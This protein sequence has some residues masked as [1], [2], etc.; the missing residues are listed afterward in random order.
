MTR[1]VLLRCD[2]TKDLYPVTKP[3]TIPHAF[4]TSQYTWHQRREHP[5]SEV[6]RRLFSS[7][8]ISCTKEKAPVLC[9]ACQLGKHVRL[10]FVSS[11]TRYKA[12]LVANGSTQLEGIDVHETFSPVV[13][14]VTIR[15]VLSLATSWHWLV[16]QLD[17]NN[18]FLH[19]DLS[20]TVY[21]HQHLGFWGSAHPDY[22]ADT[23]YLLLYIDDIV[24]DD[25]VLTAFSE[26][27]YDAEILERAHMVNCNPNRSPVDT[28]SKLG[29]DVQQVCLYMHDSRN[30]YFSALKRTLW[31]VRG[32][33]N[34]V[35]Q[36]FSSSTT[37]LVAY[38]NADWAGCPTTRRLTS[39]YC[40]FLCNNLL[41]WSSKRQPTL[42]HSSVEAKY[43][44]VANV[45]AETCWLENL[46]RE[47]HT[48]LSSATLVYCDN[49]NAIYLSVNLVQHQRTKL[50]E[51]DIHFV[52]DLVDDGQVRVL[53]VLSRYQCIEWV[54]CCCS[55][56]QG[57]C[58]N[59]KYKNEAYLCK[60]TCVKHLIRTDACVKLAMVPPALPLYPGIHG[61]V[62]V[63]K[64]PF[65]LN[66]SGSQLVV[67]VDGS[68]IELYGSKHVPTDER[69]IEALI[70]R[71]SNIVDPELDEEASKTRLD[72]YLFD[73][74]GPNLQLLMPLPELVSP[75]PELVIH[76]NTPGLTSGNDNE[77]MMAK[78]KKVKKQCIS[79]NLEAE[80]N[81]RKRMRDNL[82]IIR[83]LVPKISKMDTIS[84]VGDTIKYIQELQEN[85]KELEDELKAF[86]EKDCMDVGVEVE[87]H[88]IGAR[89]YLLKVLC[90]HKPD[91]FS[92]LIEA[93]QS[94]GLKVI[95]VS[96]TTCMGLVLNTLTVEAKEEV[97]AKSL[98][99]SLLRRGQRLRHLNQLDV[100][101]RS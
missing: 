61:E 78:Q 8:S 81:R 77:F 92:M 25:I 28:E 44:S 97:D 15:T 42:S 35:L 1:R 43:R 52:Q 74:I 85:A 70:A 82:L 83:S 60:D 53:H 12:R 36:L 11:N 2:S 99:D 16:H 33:F 50:I 3:S 80:R 5:G 90:S 49:V 54:G 24:L 23:A 65:W 84:I 14:P 34:H 29:D 39:G 37:S 27:K 45:V 96:M 20:E 94:L 86:E 72:S 46:L 89:K 40:V 51:I 6:L 31:Y 48:P 71:L 91:G 58:G 101:G 41:S 38:S 55:G 19:G 26:C 95:N 63:S 69:T 7:N 73:H 21:M 68:L 18:A 76:P 32:T 4:L 56:S 47:L 62:A 67:P 75:L 9:H 93:F 64:Q 13:K 98:K 79:K 87:V 100:D 17:V 57:V 59:V 30:P 88:K 10:P 22:G 66:L